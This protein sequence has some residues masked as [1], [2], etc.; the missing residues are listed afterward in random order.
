M[1]D[2]TLLLID[3][4]PHEESL[5]RAL[6]DAYAAG[7]ERA[8]ARVERLALRELAFDLVAGYWIPM[9]LRL[10]AAYVFRD[11]GEAQFYARLGLSL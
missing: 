1:N 8:G 3:G 2:G 4:H 9:Q 10:G 11:P 5:G 7:A 6:C